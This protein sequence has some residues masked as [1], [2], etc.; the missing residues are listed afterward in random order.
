VTPALLTETFA[1]LRDR[2][3]APVSW[4]CAGRV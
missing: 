1:R 4:F 2:A 3:A